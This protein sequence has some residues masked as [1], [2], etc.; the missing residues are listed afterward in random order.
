MA[1]VGAASMS[2]VPAA[3]A[4]AIDT[5]R[6]EGRPI[7]Y[8][9]C[10]PHFQNPSGVTLSLARRH[11]LTEVCASRG[12][13]IVGLIAGI[14]SIVVTILVIAFGIAAAAGIWNYIVLP[15]II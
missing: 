6:A 5:A 13:L 3:V 4:E 10:I 12:V 11:E 8:L 7:S 9:Y 14:L 1:R 15:E 2:V